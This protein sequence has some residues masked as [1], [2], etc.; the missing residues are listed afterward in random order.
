MKILDPFFFTAEFPQNPHDSIINEG[1]ED[2]WAAK[3]MLLHYRV[4]Q[5]HWDGEEIMQA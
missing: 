1:N 2:N 3:D 5:Q 4:H